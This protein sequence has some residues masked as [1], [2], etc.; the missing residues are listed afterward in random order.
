MD[1]T[2][3][4]WLGTYEQLQREW[5]PAPAIP[6]LTL[7]GYVRGHARDFGGREAL[8]YGGHGL[9]YAQLDQCADQLAHVLRDQGM[10]RGDVVG[11]QLPNIPQLVL[12]LVA[13]ARLGVTVT[14]IAPLLTAPEVRQQARDA[15]IKTLITLDDLYPE[16]VAPVLDELPA[17]EQV[18]VTRATDFPG[19]TPGTP[20]AADAPVAVSD[21]LAVM[22]EASTEPLA[23]AGELDDIFCLLYTGGTTGP[24][25]GARLSARNILINTLQADT[26]YSFRPGGELI[27]SAFPLFHIGGAAILFN[28][29]RTGATFILVP[30][31][32]DLEQFCRE[33]EQRPPT[34]LAGVPALYQMLLAYEPFRYLDFA[35]LRLAISGAAPFSEADIGELEALIGPDKFCEVYG[36]TE[37]GPVQTV[38]P[39]GALKPGYVG[40]PLPGTE[41]RIVDEDD[42][43]TRMPAGEPGEIM[44]CG[45]QVMQGYLYMPEATAEALREHDGR[46]W[47]HTGDVAF[48]DEDGYIKICDRS[49]DM[50]IVGGYKVF[51]VEIENKLLA[52]PEVA[53]CAVVGRPDDKRP[54]NDVVQLYVQTAEDIDPTG[55]EQKLTDFCRANMAPYKVPREIHFVEAIPLTSV[56][57]I[58]KKALR[59]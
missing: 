38:N 36:M 39:P 26:F 11:I 7:S 28:A 25:K 48:M 21:L 52:L 55:L 18:L 6:D 30:D 24:P 47:M 23:E 54:G 49:K 3:H 34:V 35:R 10:A 45:P 19:V 12:A 53:M 16:S 41:V 31:P 59:D 13:A 4:P 37:T 1:N 46:T 27:A 22:M 51:S 29:L 56:G 32:R 20:F 9:S 14:S 40:I 58:D 15:G 8:V 17:L 43:Q 5:Q 44:V 2:A 57:K 42:G 33:M 50:L